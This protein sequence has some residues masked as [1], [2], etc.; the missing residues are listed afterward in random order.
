MSSATTNLS[1]LNNTATRFL[2]LSQ[3]VL[4]ANEFT[5]LSQILLEWHSSPTFN[6]LCSQWKPFKNSTSQS[7]LAFLNI[8]CFN[9]RGLD[10]RW[11]EVCLLSTSHQLDA[12]VLGEVGRIDLSLIGTSFSN[13]RYFHQKG[14]I[15]T[16]E[17][18]CLSAT[19]LT[20][21]EYLG[22]CQMSV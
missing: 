14:R 6:Q 11:G 2:D 18:S 21:Q 4:S 1:I 3:N 10:R 17:F 12:L 15:R 19:V 13:Y 20:H 16:E 5:L 22:R 9:V 7:S 8:L